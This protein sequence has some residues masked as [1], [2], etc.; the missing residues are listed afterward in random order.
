MIMIRKYRYEV[1]TAKQVSNTNTGCTYLS[2]HSDVF[3]KSLYIPLCIFNSYLFFS[4]REE[5]EISGMFDE[6]TRC[7][8][9][10]VN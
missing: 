5:T 10:H 9:Q 1:Y 8:V 4:Q 3:S 6:A 7:F 2:V